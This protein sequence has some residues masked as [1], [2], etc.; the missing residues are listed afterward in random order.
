MANEIQLTIQM[1]CS[2]D[3]LVEQFLPGTVQI[4]Q[5]AQGAHCP[6]VIVNSSAEEDLTFGDIVTEGIVVGRNLDDT[7]YVTIGP[8]TG[9][10]MYPFIRV[11]AGEPFAFRLDPSATWRWQANSA[12]VKVQIKMLEN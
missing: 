6:T 4:N 1:L 2:N 5:S 9:G 8:S 10:A 7:N 12:N 3:S 11:N